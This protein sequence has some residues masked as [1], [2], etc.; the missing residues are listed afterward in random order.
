MFMENWFFVFLSFFFF[1]LI[2]ISFKIQWSFLVQKQLNKHGWL[3]HLLPESNEIKQIFLKISTGISLVVQWL[4]VCLLDTEDTA[5]IPGR[6]TRML[7]A[8]GG[9][10][11]MRQTTKPFSTMDPG[12]H[13]EILHAAAK[14]HVNPNKY[15]FFFFFNSA[16]SPVLK[17]IS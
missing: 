6:G 12:C 2:L 11:P 3:S 4:R 9:T 13:K 14:T 8:E 16:Q 1:L 15:I 7:H 5:S 17:K 10:K